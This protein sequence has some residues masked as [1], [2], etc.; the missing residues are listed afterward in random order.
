M[1]TDTA[2]ELAEW[3]ELLKTVKGKSKEEIQAMLDNARVNPR[4]AEAR[5]FF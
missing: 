1:S 2:E 3:M 5:F 4:N